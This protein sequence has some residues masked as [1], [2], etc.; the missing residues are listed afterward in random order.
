[1]RKFLYLLFL[2]LFINVIFGRELIWQKVYGGSRSEKSYD[3]KRDGKSYVIV[4]E[5]TSFGAGKDVYLL[6]INDKGEKILEKVFGGPKDDFGYSII[7]EDDGYLI[8]GG[9]KSFGKG[10]TDVYLLKVDKEG[11]LL[12]QKTYGDKGADEGWKILKV[13][14][15]NYLIV[16]KT[17]SKGNYD[18]YV[19]KVDKEG[20]LV[21]EKNF[22]GKGGDYAYSLS[23]SLDNTFFIV[24]TTNSFRENTDVYLLKIDGDGNLIFEKNFGKDGFDFG[25]GI[26]SLEDGGA[27]IV[28]NTNS[29]SEDTD[30]YII[31]I[32]RDGNIIWEKHFGGKGSDSAFNIEKTF[33]GNFILVGGSNSK[34]FGGSDLY[35][36]KITKDGELLWEEFWGGSDLDEGWGI[37]SLPDGY[38]ACGRS[39][40]FSTANSEVFVVRLRE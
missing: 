20:N 33:D 3:I 19:L 14:D 1:M 37:I 16:G 6:K 21:W 15:N 34:G 8:V 4:G 32:D 23:P 5:T 30:V 25:Y 7:C 29:F 18:V 12:W 10:N 35:L 36:L 40:S 31:K 11:N 27:I 9:T 38:I 26:K 28:G 17:N 22:G 2:L 24:G 13:K 39:E